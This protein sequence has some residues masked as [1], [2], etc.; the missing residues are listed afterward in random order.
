MR[1]PFLRFFCPFPSLPLI[2]F[3]LFPRC[4]SACFTF[5]HRASISPRPRFALLPCVPFFCPFLSPPLILCVFPSCSAFPFLPRAR[6]DFFLRSVLPCLFFGKRVFFCKVG[7]IFSGCGGINAKSA[8]TMAVW[9]KR[10]FSGFVRRGLR[11]YR[12][13]GRSRTFFTNGAVTT[14]R[15]DCFL[16][17][18]RAPGSI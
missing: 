11:S 9:K 15:R 1:L 4:R 6:T 8:H 17:Q 16:R 7:T 3:A 13:W 12:F 2:L 14:A 18:T 5:F 10:R